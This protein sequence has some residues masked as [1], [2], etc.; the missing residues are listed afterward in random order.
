MGT[1]FVEKELGEQHSGKRQERC[2]GSVL[3]NGVDALTFFSKQPQLSIV[4]PTFVF[5]GHLPLLA[6]PR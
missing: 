1:T 6:Y 2:Q 3:S 5:V 4:I